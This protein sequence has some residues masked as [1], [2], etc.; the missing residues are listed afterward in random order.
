MPAQGA[1]AGGALTEYEILGLV[2]HIRYDISGADE[3]GEWAEEYEKWCSEDSA[4]FL[5]LE[6]G[7]MTFES[8]PGVGTAPR[9]G[10]PADQEIAA[11]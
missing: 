3:A 7:S 1:M 5:G 6:D 10:T 2:C 11:G 9:L 4:I 8:L